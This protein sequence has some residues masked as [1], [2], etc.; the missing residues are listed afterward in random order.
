MSSYR[1]T[2]EDAEGCDPGC[3]DDHHDQACPNAAQN[4]GTA[5]NRG[6]V[7]HAGG[8]AGGGA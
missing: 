4:R 8:N 1:V 2:W 7:G 5:Q 6:N 3:D